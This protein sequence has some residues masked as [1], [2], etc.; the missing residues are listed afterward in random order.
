MLSGSFYLWW[1]NSF[2]QPI[3]VYYV[4]NRWHLNFKAWNAHFPNIF[5]NKLQYLISDH[6]QNLLT[7]MSKSFLLLWMQPTVIPN[8]RMVGGVFALENADVLLD[9]EDGTVTKVGRFA[10]SRLVSE[11]FSQ[12]SVW[13]CWQ[14]DVIRDPAKCLFS[15]DTY[16]IPFDLQPRGRA[17]G[18]GYFR[19]YV[20]KCLHWW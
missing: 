18:S 19:K 6:E 9:S 2:T 1:N 20:V 11:Q 13:T 16:Q 12:R 14:R 3:Y 5:A 7:L 17:A 15:P 8:V 10:C 4:T